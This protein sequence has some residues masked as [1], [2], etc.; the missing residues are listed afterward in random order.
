MIIL[1]IREKSNSFETSTLKIFIFDSQSHLIFDLSHCRRRH[2]VV[3]L[4]ASSENEQIFESLKDCMLR[5]NEHVDRE[6]Y[7]FVL[8]RIKKS[9]LREK[10]KV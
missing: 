9:K 8:H 7:A 2:V 5:L 1:S 6:D 4:L 3:M 10:R